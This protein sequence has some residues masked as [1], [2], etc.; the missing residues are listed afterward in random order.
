[1]ASIV[2]QSVVMRPD[3]AVEVV[4][5]DDRD[6]GSNAQMYRTLVFDMTEFSELLF[7]FSV[8]VEDLVDGVISQMR[9]TPKRLPGNT[10]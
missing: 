1:M 7:E 4:Y 9:D 6:I 10:R 5:S 8:A 3:G 2:L